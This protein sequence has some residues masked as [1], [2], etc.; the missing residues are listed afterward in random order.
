MIREGDTA[1]GIFNGQMFELP[2]FGIAL[3]IVAGDGLQTVAA[4]SVLQ[5]VRHVHLRVG[6]PI[7]SAQDLQFRSVRAACGIL[8]LHGS[9]A[10]VVDVMS[11]GFKRLTSSPRVFPQSCDSVALASKHLDLAAQTK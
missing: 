6:R 7:N 8:S 10:S 1:V 4:D 11:G 3:D 2:E 9:A 5:F